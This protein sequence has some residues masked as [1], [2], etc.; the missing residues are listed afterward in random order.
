MPV[1]KEWR[2][3]DALN[4]PVIPVFTS[5][6]YIPPL[7]A[8][9]L[10]IQIDVFNLEDNIK[11][12]R[13]LII[14]KVPKEA[15]AIPLQFKFPK[16]EAETVQTN[17]STSFILPLLNFCMENGVSIK[18]ILVTTAAGERVPDPY[19]DEP[20]SNVIAKFGSEFKIILE[21]TQIIANFKICIIGEEKSG[22]SKLLQYCVECSYDDEYIPTIG[23]DHWVK[24]F[25]H[26][27]PEKDFEITL[28]FWDLGGSFDQFDTV[29]MDLFNETDGIFIVGDLTNKE[30]FAQIES[31][32]LPNIQKNLNMEVPIILLANKCDLEADIKKTVVGRL[33]KKLGIEKVF[34]TSAKTGENVDEAFKSII[35]ILIG[36]E[37]KIL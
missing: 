34:F 21:K 25:N 33:A 3:A 7:L 29:K 4:K 14:K 10:G 28:I 12:L 9:R 8:S 15:Q 32:W 22:K 31:Y 11:K 2:S 20:V 18:N 30:S 36:K 16:T 1:A 19:F 26:Q 23:V 37:L 17:K 35:P 13:T 5:P 24:S 6:E 27:S